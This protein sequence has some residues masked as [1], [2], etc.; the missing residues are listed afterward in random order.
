[1]QFSFIDKEYFLSQYLVRIDIRRWNKRSNIE[2]NR[3]PREAAFS[4]IGT[5]PYARDRQLETDLHAQAA[6][7]AAE[8]AGREQSQ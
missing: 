1:M 6:H 3:S 7:N 2:T 8:C 4:G 5:A